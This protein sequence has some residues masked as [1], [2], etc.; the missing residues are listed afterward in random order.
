MSCFD[1]LLVGMCSLHG[2]LPPH[3]RTSYF[4]AKVYIADVD[5]GK[6]ISSGNDV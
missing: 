2:L 6:L 1:L 5:C 3:Y 4:K